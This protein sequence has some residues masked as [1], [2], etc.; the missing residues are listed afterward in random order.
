MNK[1]VPAIEREFLIDHRMIRKMG[2]DDRPVTTILNKI[3][4]PSLKE[5]PFASGPSTNG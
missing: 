3:S 2:S 1:K 4:S 5:E